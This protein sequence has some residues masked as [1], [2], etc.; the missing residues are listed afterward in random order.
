M[1]MLVIAARIDRPRPRLRRTSAIRAHPC[2]P[3]DLPAALR[4]RRR[5][6]AGVRYI[7]LMPAHLCLVVNGRIVLDTPVDVPEGVQVRAAGYEIVEDAMDDG[8]RA[9]RE[10][11]LTQG[12][13]EADAGHLV[14]A[15]EVLAELAR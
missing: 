11:A 15:D 12:L 14:D 10:R 9:A 8:E 3:A 13:A 7:D 5:R 4:A 1:P 2:S 6:P